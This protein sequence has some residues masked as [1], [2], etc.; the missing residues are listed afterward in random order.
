MKVANIL[1]VKGKDVITAHPHELITT[2]AKRIKLARIGALIVTDPEGAMVGIISERDIVYAIA[3]HEGDALNM[4]V[5]DLMTRQVRTC[6]ADDDLGHVSRI[7]TQNRIRHLPVMDGPKL[8]GMISLG[9]VVK[10][11]LD[12]MSLEA[13]VLRDVAISRG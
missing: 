8:V 12:E 7:M 1:K 2:L 9:D 4:T 6:S 3:E 11:R 5:S 10:I 13:N